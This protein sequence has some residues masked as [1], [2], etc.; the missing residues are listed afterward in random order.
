M[1]DPYST[2]LLPIFLCPS[3]PSVR[4]LP[5]PGLYAALTLGTRSDT[6]KWGYADY[7]S[8]DTV[9]NSLVFIANRSTM[10]AKEVLGALNLGPGPVPIVSIGDG[11]SNTVL[12]AEC[13]GRPTMLIV[14]NPS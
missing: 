3:S 4:S 10:N 12:I 1:N 9:R 2:T 8:I 5:D 7:A 6:P 11:L 14:A 13:S